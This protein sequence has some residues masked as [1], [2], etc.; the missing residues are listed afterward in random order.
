MSTEGV[1]CGGLLKVTTT[2]HEMRMSHWVYAPKVVNILTGEIV[3]DLTDGVWD[4]A[5]ASEVDGALCLTLQKYPDG[6]HGYKLIIN[7]ADGALR[8]GDQLLTKDQVERNLDA[9]V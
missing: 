4:L 2:P 7:P 5:G 8:V 3:L 1:Y 9:Y 6:Q